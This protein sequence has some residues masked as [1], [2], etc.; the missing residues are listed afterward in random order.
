MQDQLGPRKWN[1]RK[2]AYIY[3]MT[4]TITLESKL[5]FRGTFDRKQVE[6][7]YL[8]ARNA[9]GEVREYHKSYGDQRLAEHDLEYFV[10]APEDWRVEKHGDDL[11]MQQ[12]EKGPFW[13]EEE[14]TS[15]WPRL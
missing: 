14:L 5:R 9:K 7:F 12:D 10:S 4:W 2:V 15:C 11:D 13:I 6:R 8:V 1:F 3:G